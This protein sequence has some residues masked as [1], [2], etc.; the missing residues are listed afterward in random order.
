MKLLY[1]LFLFVLSLRFVGAQAVNELTLEIE[2]AG[3][4]GIIF[5]ANNDGVIYNQ[6]F[7]MA[8]KEEHIAF[9]EKTVLDIG[10]LTK[11]FTAAAIIQ[12]VEHEKIKLTDTL[13]KYFD[14]VPVKMQP[15]TIH[16]LL[17]H[18][19]GLSYLAGN[20]Y[21][22][23][24]KRVFLN[25]VF[26]STLLFSPGAGYEYSNIGFGLLTQVIEQVT[27]QGYEEYIRA[28]VLLP[29]GLEKT[30]Y[31]LISR[32]K[33]D[34][35]VNYVNKPNLFER[36]FA[37]TPRSEPIGHPLVHFYESLG[38]R[39]NIEGSSGYLSTV[40]DMYL[41]FIAMKEGTVLTKS[42]WDLMFTPFYLSGR[43]EHA[44]FGYGWEID[45]HHGMRRAFHKS[46]GR[47]SFAM[48]SYY[49]EEDLFMF[50]VTNFQEN[51][52]EQLM[53]RLNFELIQHHN[54]F[55]KSNY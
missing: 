31:R 16:H 21:D 4:S 40:N 44:A 10:S 17:T 38:Q 18:T 39:W 22:L 53:V 30:G 23:T 6:T 11:L 48:I 15:I 41:W 36:L 12:L 50:I 14:N 52:P 13:V 34:L 45:K 19:S 25:R 1:I 49:P 29:A 35:V 8:N 32:K 54:K 9:N 26:Q 51:Y 47:G 46:R 43:A 24:N 42:S 3:F 33:E 7:G 37:L 55:K 2:S 27:S 20:L 28:N 5:A